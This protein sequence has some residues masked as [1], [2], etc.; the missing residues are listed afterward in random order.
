MYSDTELAREFKER[1][2]T[3]S[4]ALLTNGVATHWNMSKQGEPAGPTISAELFALHRGIIKVN[5]IQHFS[6]SIGYDIGEPST[7]Y[8]D[9]ASTIKVIT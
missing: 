4:L 6:L 5:D 7:V 1:R 3:A 8:K 2:S 9:N